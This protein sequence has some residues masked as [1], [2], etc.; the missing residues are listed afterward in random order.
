[1]TPRWQGWTG[2]AVRA[3]LG[4][5]APRDPAATF[6]EVSTDTRALRSG[7]LFVALAGERFDAHDY[8]GAAREA[9]ARAAVVRRG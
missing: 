4:S 7:A 1:M 3:A 5:A 8:L 2:A 9:G 6:T